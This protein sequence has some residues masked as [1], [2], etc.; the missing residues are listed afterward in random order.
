MVGYSDWIDEES[1]G[2]ED[3]YVVDQPETAKKE[4]DWTKEATE[5]PKR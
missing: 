2:S 4:E 1:D 5:E 3:E